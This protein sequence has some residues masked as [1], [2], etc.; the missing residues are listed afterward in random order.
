[1]SLHSYPWMDTFP[2]TLLNWLVFGA[3]ALIRPS[4]CTKMLDDWYARYLLIKYARCLSVRG[5]TEI[6][7]IVPETFFVH[8]KRA[9]LSIFEASYKVRYSLDCAQLVSCSLWCCRKFWLVGKD[10]VNFENFKWREQV[11]CFPEPQLVSS[12]HVF[13][14]NLVIF[15]HLNN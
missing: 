15:S 4:I 14:T 9:L 1:M 11:T 13:F 8:I 12:G 2:A 7:N 3:A 10:H 6:K 5:V